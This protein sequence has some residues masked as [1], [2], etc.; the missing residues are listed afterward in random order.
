MYV[1]C[2]AHHITPESHQDRLS[3]ILIDKNH[4]QVGGEAVEL[5]EENMRVIMVGLFILY[6][7]K[8]KK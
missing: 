4:S 8:V 7:N 6:M 1:D 3:R 2:W 5:F